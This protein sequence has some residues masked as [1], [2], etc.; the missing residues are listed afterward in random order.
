MKGPTHPA[1]R[2][3]SKRI[4]QIMLLLFR[5]NNKLSDYAYYINLLSII[6]F[7]LENTPTFYNNNTVDNTSVRVELNYPR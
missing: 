3:Q 4:T 7:S 6:Y 1:L 2:K 5:S